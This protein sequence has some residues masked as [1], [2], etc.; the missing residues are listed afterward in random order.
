MSS[1]GSVIARVYTSSAYIPLDNVPVTFLKSG[2]DNQDRLL[3]FRYTDSSGLTD[4]VYVDT[5]DAA[6]SQSPALS[7]APYSLVDIL[8][9]YPNYQS[10]HAEYIQ[11]FP[12]VTT[13]QE[14]QLE[15]IGIQAADTQIIRPQSQQ[16]L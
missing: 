15:P 8:V 5:P 1:K 11:I 2:T 9:S 14:I 4:P 7:S 10:V 12:S 6:G 13:I 3:A 16:N